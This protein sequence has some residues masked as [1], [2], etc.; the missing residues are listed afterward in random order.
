MR[1]AGFY[2]WFY[3]KKMRGAAECPMSKGEIL[4]SQIRNKKTG[5]TFI[6]KFAGRVHQSTKELVLHIT[7]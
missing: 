5:R 4:F 6:E 1:K 2:G 7:Y 3:I